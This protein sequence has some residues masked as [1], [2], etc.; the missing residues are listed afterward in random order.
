MVKEIS[1]FYE[2]NKEYIIGF[3]ITILVAVM[4]YFIG[5]F[6]DDAV[7]KNQAIKDIDS[8]WSN[9]DNINKQNAS[10]GEA[11]V[12]L[13]GRID[14]QSTLTD[15]VSSLELSDEKMKADAVR[16]I[17][18]L[19]DFFMPFIRSNQ[20][21]LHTIEAQFRDNSALLVKRI[22]LQD[23]INGQDRTDIAMLKQALSYLYNTNVIADK[24]L[25]LSK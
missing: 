12:N 15:R 1:G 6:R 24:T 11:L 2:R 9:V 16:N 23:Q 18:D 10:Q 8:L 4:A 25:T 13:A 14:R 20:D 17:M 22:D 21:G 7:F 19:K 5:Q 3:L